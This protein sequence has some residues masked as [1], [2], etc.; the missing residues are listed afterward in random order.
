MNVH[1]YREEVSPEDA[2]I[3]RRL[4]ERSRMFTSEEVEVAVELVD[5]RLEKGPRSGYLFLFAEDSGTVLGYASYG[6]T[7]CTESSF[8]LYWIIVDPD[9]RGRGIGTSLMEETEKR[10]RG[11]GGTRVYV[12][13]SSR[14]NYALTR[15]FYESCGYRLEAIL[16]EFYGPGDAL[17]IYVKELI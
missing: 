6:H 15:G 11:L 8:D 1:V 16:R 13:T 5:E 9:L 4:A 10:V 12:E 3:V 14:E 2:A 7:P 17:H